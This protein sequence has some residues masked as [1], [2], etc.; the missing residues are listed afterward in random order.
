MSYPDFDKNFYDKINA[1]KEF[2]SLKLNDDGYQHLNPTFLD[3]IFSSANVLDLQSHQRFGRNYVNP[4]T[5]YTRILL[6]LMT[7]T[8]K[9]VESLIIAMGF[10]QLYKKQYRLNPRQHP[11]VYVLGFTKSIYQ[12]ELLS[13]PEL[14][15]V[16]VDDIAERNRLKKLAD[17]GTETDKQRYA[18]FKTRLKRRLS[19]PSYGGFFR[20][21]GYKA[22]FN[23]L[24]IFS[25][26]P[27]EYN[28][29][30]DIEDGLANGKITLNQELIDTFANSVVICD[31]IHDVYNS[32]EKNNYGIAIQKILD[33]YDAREERLVAMFL[34]ATPINNSPAEIV[35]LLNLIVPGAKFARDEFFSDARTLKPG[36]LKRI[37]DL[38]VGRVSFLR[39]LRPKY[40]PE[41]IIVGQPIKS[42]PYLKFI[43][44]EMSPLHY[45]TYKKFY[46][47]TLPPD[48]QS[49]VDFVI[50]NPESDKIGLFRTGE[51]VN[52]LNSASQTWKSKIG[53][54][55]IKVEKSD[56]I[57][58]SYLEIDTLRKYTTKYHEMLKKLISMI[59]SGKKVIVYHHYVHMSGILHINQILIYNGFVEGDTTPTGNTRCILCGVCMGKHSKVKGHDFRPARFLSV[60][61]DVDKS[62]RDDI[63]A[64]FNA[65]G[66]AH[67]YDYYILTG[68]KVIQQSEDFKDVQELLILSAPSNIPTLIQIF[69]RAI[70]NK[71][72]I[73]LPPEQRKVIISIFV[74]SVPGLTELSYEEIKYKENLADYKIIQII[75]REINSI[76]IDSYIN[77]NI[78]MPPG[79]KKLAQASPELGDLYFTIPKPKK[80]PLDDTTFKLYHFDK[81]IDNITYIIKRLFYEQSHVW[82]EED[83]WKY[84]RNPPFSVNYNPEMF[85]REGFII[86]LERLVWRENKP[87]VNLFGS[88]T[89]FVGQF[90]NKSVLL[91]DQQSAEYNISQHGKYLIML[92]VNREGVNKIPQVDVDNWFRPIENT[93]NTSLGITNYIQTLNLSY[94]KVKDQFIRKYQNFTIPELTSAIETYDNRFHAKFIEDIIRYMFLILTNPTSTISEFHEF[95]IKML[96]FYDKLNLILFADQLAGNP[97]LEALYKPYVKKADESPDRNQFLITSVSKSSAT[98]SKFDIGNLNQFIEEIHKRKGVD[99]IVKAPINMLPVGHFMTSSGSGLRIFT[100]GAWVDSPENIDIRPDNARENDLIV[101]YLEKNVNSLYINFKLRPPI[102]KM[103]KRTDA[104]KN[105]RGSACSNKKKG[106]LKQIL[107]ILDIKS[108]RGE[109]IYEMCDMVKN[110]LMRRE[111]NERRKYARLSENERRQTKRVIWFYMHYERH[112]RF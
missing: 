26:D 25:D 35:D 22:F 111:I 100:D 89:T 66:N 24:F 11:Y 80:M 106:E 73:N 32:N 56:T 38:L 44:C 39:D 93:A 112:L 74:S 40:F 64:Q 51:V 7:G 102:Q 63:V 94:G 92:P 14:G 12:K 3:H 28:S 37:R 90:H 68:S 13:R 107:K 91:I 10:I 6:K 49:L 70:R 21:I 97:A 110:E 5:P 59:G 109:G 30:Q 27:S 96:Y 9:T 108:P 48:G 50:P 46:D 101:G 16:S 84:V 72:H 45:R 23:R 18:E 88:P 8:G 98:Y 62:R 15:F 29:E 2:I 78:I 69:G 54:E 42:L 17:A 58:G 36:A 41:R 103:F 47:E 81:E 79:K 95:Y 52:M 85:S 31:E 4:D 67:G 83:L 104:R 55:M 33:I 82:T 65:P 99:K 19:K 53:V 76:A 20:F 1:K 86:A 57:S 61:S 105:V 71:S 60:Y 77:R 75:E 34:S 87:T 43:R